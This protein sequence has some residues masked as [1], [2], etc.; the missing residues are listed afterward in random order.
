MTI[1]LLHTSD[2]HLGRSLVS[3][4]RL[5]EQEAF[6]HWLLKEIVTRHIDILVVAGD[7]FDSSTPGTAAQKVYYSFLRSLLGTACRHVVII[8]GNHDSPSFLSAPGAILDML[9]VHVIGTVSP[10]GISDATDA[11]FPP[12]VLVL[13]LPPAGEKARALVCCAVPYLRERDIRLAEAGESMQAKDSNALEGI[14]RHYARLG[15]AAQKMRLELGS[16]TPL[17]VTGHLFAAGGKV[18]EGDGVRELAVGS[19]VAV[20]VDVFPKEADYVALGH[21]HAPQIVAGQEHIRYSGAPLHFGFAE[22]NQ[23]KAVCVVTF[24]DNTPVIEKVPV[25][26]AQRLQAVQGD[27]PTLRD[28]LEALVATGEPVWVEAEYN[29]CELA[30]NL[31]ETLHALVKDSPVELL[32]VRNTSRAALARSLGENNI[33]L[34]DM[35]PKEVFALCLQDSKVPDT[36]WPGLTRLHDL[37]LAEL[38]EESPE[39]L[40]AEPVGAADT[41]AGRA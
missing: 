24:T 5:A 1:R 32:R 25:P 21:L 41:R 16:R 36:Q 26:V 17:V 34:K 15:V 33:S 10:E 19:L 3:K 13:D 28:R 11:G 8:A 35:G 9:G 14:R 4:K 18:V 31:E 12:E 27:L 40:P 7:V 39:P 30:G 37:V 23:E 38:T 29:G 6:L 2:W 20:P 22:T